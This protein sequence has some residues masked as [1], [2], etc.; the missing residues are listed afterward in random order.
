[1]RRS[2]FSST[3]RTSDFGTHRG[4]ADGA[5]DARI[6]RV[7]DAENVAEHDLGDGRDRGTLEVQFEPV[8]DLL[9]LRRD[10]LDR[11]RRRRGDLGSRLSC[12]VGAAVDLGA[13]ASRLRRLLGENLLRITRR[14]IELADLA[15]HV[16][17]VATSVAA[18]GRGIARRQRHRHDSQRR[19]EP[20]APQ[21]ARAEITNTYHSPAHPI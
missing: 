8:A 11:K 16:V 10:L 2:A 1:V 21:P 15:E 5:L 4:Q 19:C 7:A 12:V 14:Q 20:A 18:D 13:G 6:D 3:Y 9:R 17:V